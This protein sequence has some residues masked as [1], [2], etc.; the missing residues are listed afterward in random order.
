MFTP[1]HRSYLTG[2]LVLDLDRGCLLRE[3]REV[4]LRKQTFQVLVFLVE[5]HGHLVGKEDLARA[6]WPDTFVSDDSLNR[7]ITEI[8]KAL[9]DTRHQLVK[10]VPRRGYIFDASVESRGFGSPNTPAADG[11]LKGPSLGDEPATHDALLPFPK[12]KAENLP[13]PLTNFIGRERELADVAAVLEEHRLLT[14][15][16]AGGCGKTRLALEAAGRLRARFKDGVWWT[17]LAPLTDQRLVAEAVAESMGMRPDGTKPIL[18]RLSEFL[19]ARSVLLVVDNCEHLRI[20]CA[21]LAAEVLPSCAAVRI[22]ATSREPL[23][24]EGEYAYPV[25]GLTLAMPNADPAEILAAEAVRL[26]VSRAGAVH[27]R[28]VLTT[29]TVRTVSDVCTRLDGVPLAIELA[30]ARG[31]VLTIEQIASRLND[32]FRLLLGSHRRPPRHQTLRA[33]IDWSH[34]QLSEPERRLFR[35]LSVFH[36]TWSLEATTAVCTDPKEEFETIELLSS[37]LNKSFVLNDEDAP[38]G[39]RYRMLETM[40]EYGRDR[41]RES[42]EREGILARHLDYFRHLAASA[43][44]ALRGADQMAWLARLRREHDNFRAALAW[45]AG[46]PDRITAALELSASLHWFWFMHGHLSES[47]RW[48]SSV[49]ARP[50]PATVEVARLT[51]ECHFAL[52]LVTVLLGAPEQGG[53]HL[54]IA[55]IMARE[56]DEE[57]LAVWTLRMITHGL[58]EEGRIAEAQRRA[59]EALQTATRLGTPFEMGAALGTLGIVSRALRDY[60]RAARYFDDQAAQHRASGERWFRAAALADAAEAEERHGN[61]A[62]AEAQAMEGLQL[63]D[64]DDTPAIA[65]NLEVLARARASRGHLLMGARLWGAAEVLRERTGLTLPAYWMEGLAEAVAVTR[66]RLG[67]DSA[68]TTAW[69]EGRA[70]TCAEAITIARSADVV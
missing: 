26:Y 37:L 49:L 53:Q 2:D 59:A 46:A 29:A 12:R 66:A 36:G 60:E 48:L 42:G 67:D 38:E 51:A 27:P 41:L 50:A 25:L 13:K 68:F 11:R 7:C 62:R 43:R 5:R 32:R 44:V 24:I 61:L 8:R 56:L 1:F 39:R 23:G 6:V 54:E 64:G 70:M 28:L 15:I 19:S 34:E 40:R 45:S 30:A 18:Q 17:D 57:P 3:G 58:I 65:W 21:D 22:I 10:T 14:L 69:T 63:A 4:T 33:T 47:Q 9:L 55:L 31:T 16:G 52:G 20:A 35:G